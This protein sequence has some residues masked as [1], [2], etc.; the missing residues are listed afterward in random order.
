MGKLSSEF[1]DEVNKEFS[2]FDYV[3]KKV[4]FRVFIVAVAICLVSTIGNVFYKEWKTDRDREIF[5]NSATYTEAAAAFLADSY[6][7]YNE[8]ETKEEK[9]AVMQYVIM[10]YPNLDLSSIENATLRQFYNQC[11]IGG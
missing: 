2:E 5:K 6:Q 3:G 8:A 11:L 4:G 7:E 9:N 1:K 10:R